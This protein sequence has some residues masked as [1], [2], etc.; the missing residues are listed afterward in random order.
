LS[1]GRHPAANRTLALWE[2]VRNSFERIEGPKVVIN[3]DRAFE[4]CMRLARKAIFLTS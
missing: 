1:E 4:E 2:S 3:T